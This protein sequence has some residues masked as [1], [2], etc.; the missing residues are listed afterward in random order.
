MIADSSR[1]AVDLVGWNQ[2]SI[3]VPTVRGS[4]PVERIGRPRLGMLVRQEIQPSAYLPLSCAC[5]KSLAPKALKP[6][7]RDSNH[8]LSGFVLLT[9]IIVKL[10][11]Y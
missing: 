5:D 11:I 6:N 2:W 1:Q 3:A 7:H 4:N 10:I 8:D 9:N